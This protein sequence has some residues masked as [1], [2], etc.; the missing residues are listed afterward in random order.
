MRQAF[1]LL[2]L[3]LAIALAGVMAYTASFYLD[4]D[5]IS[6]QNVKTQLQSHFNI[7]TSVILQCK[8][9]SNV[10]PIQ[11]NGS[12][13]SG[14]LLSTLECNTTTPYQLDG[15]KGSF[16]PPALDNFTAY[17]ATQNGSEFYF[18]TTTAINSV[19]DEV[20]L[21]LNTTYSPNQY[22]LTHDATTAFLNF[23]LSR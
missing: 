15:G 22:E 20:L 19:N 4:I 17:T 8:E 10:F 2:E 1:S 21:E 14:T 3:L 23:Y 11:S 18:S 9:H 12:L 6:K 7:I 13:A 5:S 16:I